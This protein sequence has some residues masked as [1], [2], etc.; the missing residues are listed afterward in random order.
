MFGFVLAIG[1]V[2][3]DAIVVIEN[4]ER[5]IREF[6]LS[7]REAAQR[8]MEEVSGPVMAIMCVLCA[9]FIP[10]AFLGGIAGQ[11]YKQFAITIAISVVISGIVALTLSPAMAA[12]LLSKQH[13]PT[14]FALW[15]NRNFDRLTHYYG[16]C[17]AWL[18]GRTAI[19]ALGFGLILAA[20]VLLNHIVPTSFVP[21]EDQGYLMAISNLPDGAS[22]DRTTNVD[23]QIF[24]LTKDNPA[25]KHFVSL[26]GFSMLDN[27]NRTSIGTNFIVLKDWSLRKA[28]D[29]QVQAVFMSLYQKYQQISEAVIQVFNPPAIQGL[30]TVGGFEFWLENRGER[31]NEALAEITN[32]FITEAYKRPEI[33][34]LMS[35]FQTNNMQLFV[36]LDRLKTRTYGIGIADV[37]QSLQVLFGSLYINNFNKYGRTFQVT[38]QAEPAYRTTADDIKQVYVRSA[39]TNLMVPLSSLVTLRWV[40]APTL[41]SRFNG[42]PA[43]RINGAAAPGYSSGQ[44]MDAMEAVAKEVLPYDMTYSWGGESFQEK[45]RWNLLRHAASRHR[46][47]L[48]DFSSLV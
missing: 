26:S 40:P 3:D 45:N 31:G 41:V 25:V 8:A 29:M 27:L 6:G 22:L 1:I 36:D 18:V 24:E 13:K 43:V 2:V 14:R 7:G 5:N 20:I 47:G 11:L 9:V 15:F 44:A 19:G 28:K 4:V 30:G 21:S 10:V 46:G 17:A 37:F 16:R 38:A 32:K 48:S 35:N 39:N 42:F 33:Q 34:G 23:N 12:I